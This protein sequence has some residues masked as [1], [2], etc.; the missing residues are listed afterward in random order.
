MNK[1]NRD[2]KGVWIPK[3]IYLNEDLNWTQKILLI[4]IDSLDNEKGCFATNKYLANFLGKSKNYISQCISELKE[5]GYIYEKEFDGRKRVLKSRLKTKS[6][7]D[8]EY[9]QRQ[10]LNIV[11]GSIGQKSNGGNSNN[12]DNSMFNWLINPSI[13]TFNN[14]DNN[15][16]D[17]DRKK[18]D[19]PHKKIKKLYN[20]ICT[21]LP[22]IRKMSEHRKKHL[23]ARWKEEEDIDVFKE[24][25]EKA[26]SSS[27][28]TGNNNRNWTADFDWIVKNDT[29]FNKILEGKYDDKKKN[30]NLPESTVNK[31]ELEELYG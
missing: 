10:H 8:F 7:A 12:A 21:S 19:V 16:E 30:N 22:S 1:Q 29:N 9:N 28:L 14:L 6:K 24:V 25:F 4:E 3:E 23:R 5:K 2:F 20:N 11:K 13:N 26:E 15:K 18:P 27:F 17:K 31:E